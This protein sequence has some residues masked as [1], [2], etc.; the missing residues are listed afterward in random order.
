MNLELVA[1]HRLRIVAHLAGADRVEDR[2]A[3]VASARD[4]LLLGQF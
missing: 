4:Q 3:D 1:D 2:R